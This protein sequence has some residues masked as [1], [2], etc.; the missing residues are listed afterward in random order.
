VRLNLTQREETYQALSHCREE[1]GRSGAWSL[2]IHE[3]TLSLN[4]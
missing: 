2:Q 1:V 3:M 4:A